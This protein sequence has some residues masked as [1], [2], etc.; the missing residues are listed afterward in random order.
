MMMMDRKYETSHK[1]QAR[2]ADAAEIEK[3]NLRAKSVK[4]E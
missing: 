3:K 2:S 4:L 1:T